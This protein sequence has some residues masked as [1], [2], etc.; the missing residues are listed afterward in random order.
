MSASLSG[1]EE[2]VP[3]YDD[4]IAGFS[5]ARIETR[6]AGSLEGGLNA[7]VECCDRHVGSGGVALVWESSD[8]A[9]AQMTFA[10]LQERSA[11][12]AHMLQARGV[13]PGDR[14]AGLLPQIPNFWSSLSPPGAWAPSISRC[15]PPSDRGRSS[16][17]SAPARPG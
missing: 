4:F 5:A 6:L 11:R 1:T 2:S 16:T 13:G 3:A 12:L 9:G 7:C 15:S 10:Q 17:V 14:V 8:G